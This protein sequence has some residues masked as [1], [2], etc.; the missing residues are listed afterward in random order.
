LAVEP[1]E[2]DGE[3]AVDEKDAEDPGRDL[4]LGKPRRANRR[5]MMATGALAANSQLVKPF[6][7]Q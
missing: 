5:R 1:A 7:A 4:V 3:Q 2:Q 6:E